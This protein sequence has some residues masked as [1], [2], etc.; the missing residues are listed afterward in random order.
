MTEFGGICLDNDVYVCQSLNRFRKFEFTLNWEGSYLSNQVL[1]GNKNARFPKL[2]LE[3]YKLYDGSKWYYN[4]GQLPTTAI[5][6]K[7]P[8]LV[9][10][11]RGEFGIVALVNCPFIYKQYISDWNQRLYA[12]HMTMR[13]NQI[14]WGDCPSNYKKFDEQLIKTL[15]VT[16]GEMARWAL[17]G[18]K[19]FIY[20]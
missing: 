2:T 17:Y 15:N 12:F 9:H 6:Y 8:E 3:T 18:K 13:G 10:R 19:E 16:F 4:A 1:I 20:D 14:S 11:I 7:Y 5:L